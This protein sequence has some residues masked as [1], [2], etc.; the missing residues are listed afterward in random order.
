MSARAGTSPAGEA[1]PNPFLMPFPAGNYRFR[2]VAPSCKY[3]SERG[4]FPSWGT[5]GQGAGAHAAKPV[6][7]LPAGTPAS[8]LTALQACFGVAARAG[9]PPGLA[10]LLIPH[11]QVV[12]LHAEPAMHRPSRVRPFPLLLALAPAPASPRL[13]CRRLQLPQP[14]HRS[15]RQPAHRAGRADAA[16]HLHI[17]H[18]R[19]PPPTSCPCSTG[20]RAT[21]LCSQTQETALRIR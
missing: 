20:A 8:T 16:G 17:H 15:R 3:G 5:S 19:G 13:L 18:Q 2:L 11:V 6:E 7:A 21:S 1:A 14:G 12:A 4:R 9:R 10:C